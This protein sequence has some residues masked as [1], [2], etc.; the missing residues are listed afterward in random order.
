[1]G[2]CE[3]AVSNWYSGKSIQIQK[4]L[5]RIGQILKI[6]KKSIINS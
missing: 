1:M 3:V 6:T 2:V 4:N 5:E